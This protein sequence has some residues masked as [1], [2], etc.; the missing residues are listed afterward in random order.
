MAEEEAPENTEEAAPAEGE[1]PEG[2]APA[3][4]GETAEA[5]PEIELTPAEI[6]KNL[7]GYGDVKLDIAAVLGNISIPVEQFV[8]LGRGVIIELDKGKNEFIDLYANGKPF[9]QGEVTV[10]EQNVGIIVKNII[11]SDIGAPK[12][13]GDEEGGDD[14][15]AAAM[16]GGDDD[17]MAAAMAEGE[18]G[19]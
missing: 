15:M 18:G 7:R 19:E 1:A 11:G 6:N 2:E 13:G 16:E 3:E 12:N 17:P 14:D 9:A 10:M 8:K 4:G 5:A